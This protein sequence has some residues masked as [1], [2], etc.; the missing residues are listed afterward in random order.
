MDGC[1]DGGRHLNRD[2]LP[3]SHLGSS[4]KMLGT[5]SVS[6]NPQTRPVCRRKI[7]RQIQ[8][9]IYDRKTMLCL[10]PEEK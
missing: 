7:N 9:R 2:I 8:S 6:G 5:D 1:L 4:L 3:S 10:G